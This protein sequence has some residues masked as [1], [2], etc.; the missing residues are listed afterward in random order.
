MP[1]AS[2]AVRDEASPGGGGLPATPGTHSA[3]LVPLTAEPSGAGFSW[4]GVGFFLG[5]LQ[6][7][8]SLQLSRER[9]AASRFLPRLCP[10]SGRLDQ[11]R[12]PGTLRPTHAE[13]QLRALA[14][15][16]LSPQHTGSS[17]SDGSLRTTHS[18][19]TAPAWRKCGHRCSGAPR[20]RAQTSQ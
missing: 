19:A 12:A 17:G 1:P 3:E 14:G 7:G 10:E 18:S 6:P 15:R 5:I 16:E 2:R 13:N 4:M 11:R 20:R 9:A 8:K